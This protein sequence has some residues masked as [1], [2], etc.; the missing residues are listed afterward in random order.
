VIIPADTLPTAGGNGDTPGPWHD[1]R[2]AFPP[3]FARCREKILP[4]IVW[5][6]FFKKAGAWQALGKLQLPT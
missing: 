1:Y 3:H 2:L 6:K 5:E 4:I